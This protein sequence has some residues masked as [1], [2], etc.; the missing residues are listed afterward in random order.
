[1]FAFAD[2]RVN[3]APQ[4][5]VRY[6]EALFVSGDFF[7]ALGCAGRRPHHQVAKTIGQRC[8]AGAAVISHA[9]WQ[10]EFGGR[11][12]ILSR[13]LSMRS[14]QVPIIGVMPAGFFGVEV[15]RRFDVALPLCA[16]GFD[17][18]DH[19][20][21]AVM[22]R[23]KPGWTA[24]QA[25]AHL[26]AVGPELLGATTPPSYSAEQ[27]KQFLTLK[28]S[29]HDA[30]NGVSPLRT[31]IRRS[32]LAAPG[33]RRTGAADRLRQRRQ[34]LPGPGDGARAGA[35][36]SRRSRCLEA[37]NHP[38]TARRRR[39]HRLCRGRP[40]GSCSHGSPTAPS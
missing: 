11:P 9:L 19:W 24:E 37:A 29:V 18:P 32:A 27:A 6:V 7:P 3:L 23:L 38:A 10:R 8:G 17:R 36:A 5:E 1:M 14:G 33:H 30:R 31:R 16:S 34:S 22:G 26:A 2:T 12:D 40:P 13:T 15:G 28:F 4:G 21:L 20:W 35:R 25:G 39:D